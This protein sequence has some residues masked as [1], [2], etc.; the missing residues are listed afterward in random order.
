MGVIILNAQ[1]VAKSFG[2]V[3][4]LRD[5]NLALEQRERMALVG[6]NGSGK[7]TL[8]RILGGQLAADGGQIAYQ[9]N[10]KIGYLAQSYQAKAGRT[11]L[12]EAAEVFNE[13][14]RIERRLRQLE[15]DMAHATPES[16]G[17]IAA[18]Y[19]RLSNAFETADGFSAESRL[20]G[21]LSGVG[22]TREQLSQDASK[23]SGGELTRLGLAR[24]LLQ[25]PDLLLLDEPT[26]HL[27][28]QALNWLEEYL[29][30]YKGAVIV[31]SHDRYFLD[32]V[33][34][35]VTEVHFGVT[36]SYAGNYSRYVAQ[37]T[38]RFDSRQK[39]YD[40]QQK[41]IKRQQ[42]IIARY[43]SFNREK[44]IRAAESREKA[45]A[46][47]ETLDRPEEE[48]QIAFRFQVRRRM[49]EDAL[50]ATGISKAFGDKQVLS[51]VS[52]A[53]RTGERSVL[54]GANGVGKSTLLECLMGNQEID[55]GE[56]W[57]GF[58]ADKGYYDQKQQTLTGSK[59]VLD[60]VWDA[61]PRLE[62]HEVRGA[63]GRFLF[64]GDDVFA[65]IDTLSGG[66]RA[67]VALTKLMLRRDN[68]LI[69]DEPTNH[70]DA[71]SREELEQALADFDGTILAVSHDRYFINR[72]ATRLLFLEQDGIL[73]FDG[74]YDAWM[75]AQGKAGAQNRDTGESRT[76]TEIVKVQRKARA[77]QERLLQQKAQVL[78]AEQ[79]VI[80]L[81]AELQ[82]LEDSLMSPEIFSD[83]TA[84]QQTSRA[85]SQ[86]KER[87]NKAY[88]SWEEAE[89]ALENP[90]DSMP[91]KTTA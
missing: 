86:L 20:Q 44:S 68:F 30:D 60:E 32:R 31:V 19:E 72:I 37:R 39:A 2:V 40:L 75:A 46:R 12:E 45:L 89:Q 81:E 27:D 78:Q 3:E 35:C 82:A 24:L 6:V 85:I 5:A 61:F 76:R 34:T 71:D 52:F 29:I 90:D 51:N 15:M 73:S 69:L 4:V 13:L 38:E 88:Y 53:M 83:H 64:S 36:E 49:G 1:H 79:A 25:Q 14:Y 47:M 21:V 33:C 59:T 16:L 10:L 11:V 54:L 56:V 7:T 87:I 41:E 70:L 57:F 17:Q 48:K 67:R 22:F 74:G 63:L 80:S 84:A 66:E 8:L 42:G 28:L 26:N 65:T 91:G 50:K 62:Q 9:K 58:N 43:R 23:L 55:R 18:E 77:E